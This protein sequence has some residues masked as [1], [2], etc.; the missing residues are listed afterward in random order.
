MPTSPRRRARS[1]RLVVV[2]ALVS[3]LAV[4]TPSGAATCG[5]GGTLIDIGNGWL[6]SQPQFPTG[7]SAVTFLA[8]PAYDPNLIY[9]SNGVAVVRSRDAGCG[10]KPV[11]TATSSIVGGTAEVTALTVPSSANSSAYVYVGVTSTTVGGLTQPA[12]AVS[13][14]YGDSWLPAGEGLPD[15]GTVREIAV[16]PQVQLVAFAVVDNKLP[17]VVRQTTLFSTSDAG[18]TWTQ[19]T[20]TGESFA[21]H[22]LL[23]DPVRQAAL[24]GL[25]GTRPVRSLDNAATFAP[26]LG[27]PGEVDELVAAPGS[28][29]VRILGSR[30]DGSGIVRSDDGGTRWTTIKTPTA[31]RSIAMAPLQ[32]L[33]AVSSFNDVWLETGGRRTT[34]TPAVGGALTQLAVSAPTSVGYAVTAVMDGAVVRAN[35]LPGTTTTI[36]P[37]PGGRP[38]LL[39][40]VTPVG[41]F[42]SLLLPQQFSIALAAGQTA[43]VPYRLLVPRTPTPVDVMFLVDSTSSYQPVIDGLRQSL[44]RVVNALNGAGLNARFGVGNFEDYPP[45][46]GIAGETNVP[47]DL[48][49]TIGPSDA[50]LA[51]AI[52]TIVA[53]DGTPD[54]G[55]S[56]YT[57]MY[58]ALT[59]AGERIDG[60]QVIDKGLDAG[61]RAGA[62]KFLMTSTDTAPHYKGQSLKRTDG[63]QVI[64]PGPSFEDVV[65]ALQAHGVRSVGIPVRYEDGPN[66]VPALRELATESDAVAPLGGVDCDG[67]G[68]IDL[69]TSDPLVCILPADGSGAAGGLAAAIVGLVAGVADPKPVAL[70]VS[71]GATRARILSRT[72]N[73]VDLHADNALD[74]DVELSCP[75]AAARTYDITLSASSP[76]RY[77]ADGGVALSCGGLPGAIRVEPSVADGPL[78]P[79][80]AAANAV[81]NPN[82][83]VNTNVNSNPNP[84]PNPHVNPVANANTGL[85]VNEEQQVQLALVADEGL[86]GGTDE[87]LAMSGPDRS[88]DPSPAFGLATAAMLA[89]ASGVAVR[90]RRRTAYAT[91][92]R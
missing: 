21:P 52:Q 11:F 15:V 59:G 81:S 14:H 39:L 76:T 18:G 67:N 17:N 56:A 83:N 26:T 41:Q 73:V 40:P 36:P 25:Q 77:L 8:S 68:T 32:D 86:R 85:A 92:R 30:A 84:H 19:R 33:V 46:Y 37:L 51:M 48:R 42:P 12:I 6:A 87:V 54:G 88:R 4:I 16:S 53:H 55:Q 82:V 75:R 58:Q 74:Y 50:D 43:R 28:G 78:P 38:V 45:P 90:R 23:V 44:A 66:A 24:Y 34:V 13:D 20:P 60:T 89:G 29:T 63:S 2:A 64:Q 69:N 57:A 49:R 1:A 70:R 22:G 91:A 10:W 47:Y 5:P 35:F 3:T 71:R 62:A 80:A 61:Y 72:V 79:R 31:P 65:A 7:P 9:A 27:N